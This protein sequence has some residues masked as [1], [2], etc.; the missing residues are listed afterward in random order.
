MLGRRHPTTHLFLPALLSFTC[1]G[2]NLLTLPRLCFLFWVWGPA[3]VLLQE[4]C[5]VGLTSLVLPRLVDTPTWGGTR[6]AAAQ[7]W[8]GG[9]LRAVCPTCYGFH[10]WVGQTLDGSTEIWSW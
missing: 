3:Q 5:R 2:F 6:P 10:T 1:P 7:H 4:Q 9:A 8:A